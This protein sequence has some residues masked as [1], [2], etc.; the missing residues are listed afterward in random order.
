MDDLEFRRRAYADP[1]DKSPEFVSAST[2]NA[3]NRQFMEELKEFNRKLERALNEPVPPALPD[4][5]MLSH[6]LRQPDQKDGLGWRH[7]AVAASIAFALGFSTRFM[8]LSAESGNQP[9]SVA[10]VAMQHV[11]MEMPFTRYVDEE[12][13]LAT[14]NAK[15]RPYGARLKDIAAVGKIYYANHCMFGGG[16]AAHLVIQG[17]H[18]RVHVFLVP[19]ERALQ[20]VAEFSDANLHG[21]VIPMT[22]N[23]L[24]VVSDKLE[25]V[26]SMAEK[27]QASLERAL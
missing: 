5:L 17:E 13:T 7:L 20:I 6:L 27:V 12:L 16:P 19:M 14:V 9:P 10:K 1:C 21:E 23:R 26:H 22:Y 2:T 24:V 8:Q 4:K 25:N 11:Q 18:E 15:L 3:G